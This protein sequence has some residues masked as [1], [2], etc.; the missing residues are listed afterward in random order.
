MD[1][2]LWLKE[3]GLA[4]HAEAFAENGVDAALLPELTNEDLKDLGVARLADRKRLLK[5][6]ASLPE[7][8]EV[9][10]DAPR[11]AANFSDAERRQLTIMFCDLV[12]STALSGSL[13]PEDYRDVMRAYQETSAA[14][15][16]RYDGY[17][18]KYLGDGILAYFGFPQAHEDDAERAVR[19]G[20]AMVEAIGKLTPRPDLSLQARI[21]IATGL[22]V[23]GD[24]VGVGVAEQRAVS[25]E[26]PNLAARL[27][28]L[29]AP[30][31]VVI[32][33]TTRRLIGDAFELA[34]LGRQDL[35]GIEDPVPA[36]RVA[37]ERALESRFEAA[38]SGVLTQFV[39]REHE[40]GLLLER[41]DRAKAGEGQAVLL[42]GEAGI[43]KSR[44][45]MAL[46][47]RIGSDRYTCLQYQASP[48]YAESAFHPIILQLRQAAGVV[49]PDT[50]EIKLDK[51][52]AYLAQWHEDVRS[53]APFLAS[54]LAV[55]AEERY[56]PIDLSPLQMKARTLEA[57]T[58]NVLAMA[59]RGPVLL[60][61]EDA[62]W[63][64][65]SSWELL[66]QVVARIS[67][68]RV[69]MLIT[70]RP[71]FNA[72]WGRHNHVTAL[73]LSRLSRLQC[74]QMVRGARG[75]ELPDSVVERISER[76]DGVPLFVEELTQSVIES[77]DLGEE[78]TIPDTLQDLLTARL[79]RLHEAKD[80]AQVGAVIGRDFPYALLTNVMTQSAAELASLLG[81]L[82]D[83]GLVHCQGHPPDA[84]YTF[85]HA[86]VQAAAYDSL[87][88]RRRQELHGRIA[89]VIEAQFPERR[90]TE[91]ELLAH[92]YSEAGEVEKAIDY[93]QRAGE[94]AIASSANRESM[95]HLK[96]GLALI[97]SLP[98]SRERARRE[99]ECQIAMGG[100]LLAAKGYGAP[101][102]GNAFVRARELCD[103]LGATA[104][105]FPVLYGQW[106][107]HAVR[108]EIEG[109]RLVGEQFLALAE[110][111]GD[112]LPRLVAHRSV[113]L[114]HLYQGDPTAALPHLE[115]TLS[116]FD[117]AVHSSSAYRYGQD[118]RASSQGWL[119]W[120][121]WHLGYPDQARRSAEEG[122]ANAR[123]LNHMHTIA[124][125]L[126]YGATMV[127]QFLGDVSA[128]ERSA[129][130]LIDLAEEQGF[131]M[132]QALG[133]TVLGWVMVE[134]GEVKP[135][136]LQ[137]NQ[138]LALARKTG[139]Q[140]LRPHSLTLL[141]EAHARLGEWDAGL[142]ALEQALQIVAAT[143]VQ[144]WEAEVYVLQGDILSSMGIEDRAESALHRALDIAR[145]QRSR[146][147][148]LRAATSLARLW[149]AQ[150]KR[151]E[152]REFLAP[153]HD[154]FTEGRD[155]RDLKSAQALLAELA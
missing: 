148:E 45:A 147:L 122:V 123:E 135:G 134:R 10:A 140:L 141:A 99:L 86:L 133:T 13:D 79:D 61:L 27:Q 70:H 76:A 78:A 81:R 73:T 116:L 57:M 129:T 89:G 120:V 105:L 83:S 41:W 35:K 77:G 84:V 1:V 25:G 138:G 55:P 102:T 64:D 16:G 7:Q 36:W 149:Q 82:V 130:A 98:D 91:P 85:K 17:V 23:V 155:T 132:W 12:G 151:D 58:G 37:G 153:I 5:A 150:G 9:G 121:L 14:I 4:E 39:G 115:R 75:S 96:K 2:G 50:H 65:P 136:I 34:D 11:P 127:H 49:S 101:D 18:A 69:L 80:I 31:Q 131:A 104:E 94:H 54:L 26:T 92:H 60:I 95:V 67:G 108:A 90:E 125:T 15:V 144:L 66:E 51:L 52:E 111:Q 62:H 74:L 93:W 43:G 103:Q 137:I 19:A 8:G 56:G 146:A 48:L 71:E 47:E 152:A 124:N 142:A 3:L 139:E 46:R 114:S 30:G 59:S 107:H 154:W 38:H 100:A 117:P 22:V 63:I 143:K 118:P 42:S 97:R 145:G 112:A 109:S 28:G 6:I 68:A 33:A 44:I 29:A 72:G 53:I 110:L 87:L 21:G 113:G 128:A 119:A 32:G 24:M 20:L 106:V 88:K 126:G 40:L